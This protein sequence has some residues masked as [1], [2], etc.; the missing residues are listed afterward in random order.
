MQNFED[1]LLNNLPTVETFHPSYNEALQA[2]IKAGGKRFRPRLLLAVVKAYEPLLVESAMIPALAVEIFHTYSLIH[3]DLPAMDNAP[4]RRGEP[5]LHIRYDEALAILAGDALNTYAF[6]LLSKAPF[7]S[8]VTLELIKILAINGGSGGMVLGQA[9]DIHF[10]RHPLELN[11]VK[12][13]HKNKTAKLIAASLEMGGVIVDLDKKK[14]QDLYDFGLLLGLL[15]Q[16]QDDILD[17]TQ[18]T[19]EAGKP[20]DKDQEKN[21]F[22][23]LLGL[24]RALEYANS[25]ASDLENRFKE[26]DKPLKEAL[27]PLMKRYLF[28]HKKQT[29]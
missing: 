21:S 20:T 22:V 29:E 23:T 19:K 5:T 7:R 3:D 8:D 11:Q 24:D 12:E 4:L 1:F 10:E 28:R 14:R 18:S 25:V 2:M 13:L 17:T 26:F 9:M 15:F 6:E 27:E 16:I